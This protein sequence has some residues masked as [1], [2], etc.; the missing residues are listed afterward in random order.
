MLVAVIQYHSKPQTKNL[1][2]MF[3]LSSADIP[4]FVEYFK[5]DETSYHVTCMLT[6]VYL[7]RVTYG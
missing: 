2:V 7:K 1:Q 5:T 4:Y 6:K 3:I